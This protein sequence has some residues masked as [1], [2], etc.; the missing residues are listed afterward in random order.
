MAGN[1]AVKRKRAIE[2]S[3]NGS[4][5]EISLSLLDGIHP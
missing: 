5:G 4:G 2:I 3:F 1:L